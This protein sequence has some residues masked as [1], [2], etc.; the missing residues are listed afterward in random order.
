MLFLLHISGSS[1]LLK[2]MKL[3]VQ[4]RKLV[5]LKCTVSLSLFQ[6]VHIVKKSSKK[7][8][9]KMCG[10]K[11]SVIKAFNISTFKTFFNICIWVFSQVFGQGSAKDCREH[12]QKLNLMKGMSAE[13][14]EN[15]TTE[16]DSKTQGNELQ[17]NKRKSCDRDNSGLY[18]F[19]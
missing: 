19:T 11:Q 13:L 18:F 15:E 2:Y 16:P 17:S 8:V 1:R 9:C 6:Q 5:V 10:E 14:T 3:C 4:N 7:W 12:V